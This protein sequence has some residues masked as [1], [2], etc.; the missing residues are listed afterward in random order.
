MFEDASQ[1]EIY[2][3]P[4]LPAFVCPVEVKEA[5]QYGEGHKGVFALSLIPK[6][7]KFWVW[8]QRVQSI[9]HT[10]LENYIAN[11]FGN[12]QDNLEEIQVFLR[13]GF[14]LPP[15]DE[16][17]GKEDHYFYT[18]PSD[19]G[20]FMNHCTNA[21]CGPDGA[22]RD[23]QPGEEMCMDYSFHGDPKWYQDICKK[24]GVLTERQ[25]AKKAL[26]QQNQYHSH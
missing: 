9:H 3:F 2:H 5:K 12:A 18:N 25:I 26:E 24:Y 17:T 23:I 20:R 1:E 16:G 7:T 11:H 15:N 22:T 19:A 13:Q 8:T 6:G 10:E 14:V 21:N 4:T